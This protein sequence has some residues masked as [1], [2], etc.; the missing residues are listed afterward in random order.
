MIGAA[1]VV[2]RRDFVATI[3]TRGFVVWLLMPII[4]IAFGFVSAAIGASSARA[5]TSVAVIASPA[6]TDAIRRSVERIK[7]V[8]TGQALVLTYVAAD[9]DPAAQA[10]RLLEP[11]A[12]GL[13]RFSAVLVV[14]RDARLF[15]RQDGKRPP[16]ARLQGLVDGTRLLQSGPKPDQSP[17]IISQIASRATVTSPQARP[18]AVGAAAVLFMLIG[19]LAGVLLTNM[20][21]EKSNKV[22]EVLAAAVPVPAIFA[23]KL[24]AMLAVSLVGIALWATIIGGAALT[25]LAN[26]PVGLVPAPAVGWPMMIL[27]S[28]AYFMTAFLIYG[29]LYLGI[30]SLCSSIREVQSLSMP[31]TIG[32]TVVFLGVMS[33]V[34]TIDGGWATV[35]RLIPLSSPYMMAA[36]AALDPDLGQHVLAI[37]WQLGF[38]ALSIWWSSRLFRAGVLHSGPPPSLFNLGKLGKIG[39]IGKIGKLT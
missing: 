27:L 13:G 29:A 12:K 22:I 2:A 35:M 20:V 3:F 8:D 7:T 30:G 18:L 37:L 21:E 15:Q 31:V 10:R 39:K 16:M 36:T 6:T 34:E 32:Q 5:D 28:L 17:L 11:R 9:A 38:A 33:A 26:A 24:A 1:F 25:L 23:G 19:L 14:G 4:G